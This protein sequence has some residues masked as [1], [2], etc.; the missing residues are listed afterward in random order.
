MEICILTLSME[1]QVI[2]PY[3]IETSISE[4]EDDWGINEDDNDNANDEDDELYIDMGEA[5]V[6]G[7]NNSPQRLNH[8]FLFSLT[9]I[10]SATP[11]VEDIVQ[12][13][14]SLP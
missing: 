13:G 8:H 12:H 1:N 5:F 2:N 10:S 6:Q 9:S 14:S 11:S 7:M 3:V 4:E